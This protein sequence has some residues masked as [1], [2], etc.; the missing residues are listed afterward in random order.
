MSKVL[1]KYLLFQN[2]TLNCILLSFSFFPQLYP[3]WNQN[4]RERL[5]MKVKLEKA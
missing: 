1:F 4:D 5:R 3:F 2:I